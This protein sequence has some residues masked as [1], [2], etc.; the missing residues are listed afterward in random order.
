[1]IKIEGVYILLGWY[2]HIWVGFWLFVYFKGEANRNEFHFFI[3]SVKDTGDKF[4]TGVSNAGDQIMTGVADTGDK[5]LDTN[6]SKNVHKN[7]KCL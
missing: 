5:S 2:T 1:V 3:T 7:S 6:D 4:I